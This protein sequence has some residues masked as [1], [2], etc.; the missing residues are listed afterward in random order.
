MTNPTIITAPEALP[1]VDIERDFDAPIASVYRAYTEPDL[2]KQWLGPRG[3]EMDV[4]AY[5]VRTGGHYRYIH[6]DPSGAEYAFRGSFHSATE[7]EQI[8]QTF[9]FEGFPGVVSIESVVFEDL[10]DGRTRTR[11]HAVYP[12]LE[13]RDGIVA[14]GMERGITEGHERLDELLGR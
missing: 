1:Y 10:G 14:S 3:Y 2:V 8:I 12:T 4:E 7:N 13:A 9:E 5:D 6:R 11:A